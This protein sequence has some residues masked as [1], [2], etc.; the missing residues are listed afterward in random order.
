MLRVMYWDNVGGPILDA[1]MESMRMHSRIIACGMA[2]SEYND[3]RGQNYKC[4]HPK[5]A[6]MIIARWTYSIQYLATSHCTTTT[7]YDRMLRT[8]LAGTADDDIW[9]STD[10]DTSEN[11]DDDISENVDD[12]ISENADD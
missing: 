5:H 4:D 8:M 6:G 10:D 1:T 11:V 2:T 3:P 9:N 7:I 12:D